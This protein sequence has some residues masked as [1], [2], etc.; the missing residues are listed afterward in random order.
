MP[1]RPGVCDLRR[2]DRVINHQYELIVMI[3]VLDLDVDTGL[4]HP[5]RDQPE[6]AGKRLPQPQNRYLAEGFDADPSDPEDRCR[7][8]SILDEIVS[9]GRRAIRKDAASPD[10][11]SRLSERF[12]HCSKRSGSILHP[13]RQVGHQLTTSII[14]SCRTGTRTELAMKQAWCASS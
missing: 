11:D 10:A 1:R 5:A 14:A 8:G 7:G 9:N 2:A 6:L 4:R 3:A 13:D 12:T